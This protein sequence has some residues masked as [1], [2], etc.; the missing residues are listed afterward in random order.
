MPI[1]DLEYLFIMIRA[2]SVSNASDIRITDEDGVVRDA[3]VNLDEIKVTRSDKHDDLRVVKLTET[4]G[5]KL[6][7]PTVKSVVEGGE[8]AD[9]LDVLIASIDTIFD[10][11]EVSRPSDYTPKEMKDWVTTLPI[12]K[13]GSVKEFFE[14]RPKVNLVATYKDKNNKPATKKI[15]GLSDFFESA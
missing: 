9:E 1:F 11:N 4:Q 3:R 6:K 2:K 13:I 12:A 5:I 14:T 8:Q 10:G 7:Y 15:E